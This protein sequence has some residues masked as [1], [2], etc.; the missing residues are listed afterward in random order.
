[1]VA[2]LVACGSSHH[3]PTVG[4]I[5]QP[6][7]SG[8]PDTDAADNDGGS[9]LL[10]G[11][12]GSNMGSG[13]GTVDRPQGKPLALPDTNVSDGTQPTCKVAS[14]CPAM[15]PNCVITADL[16][17]GGP[18]YCSA[19]YVDSLTFVGF[20]AGAKLTDPS[21]LI[22]VC[23]K[24]EHT[25][26]PDLQIELIAPDGKS[27]ILRQFVGRSLGQ[28]YLGHANGCDDDSK[29]VPGVGYEYCW[30]ASAPT[31]MLTADFSTCGAAGGCEQWDGALP[32]ICQTA[33]SKFDVVPAGS[34][35]PDVSFGALK[36]AQLNGTWTFRVTDLWEIDNGFL[37]DWSIQFDSSLVA[38]CSTP[39]I[40]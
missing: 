14:D 35:L 33:G 11:N 27:V 12:G 24:L 15:T 34:Y 39:L 7:D 16:D 21:K 40:K 38:D 23:A 3:P 20:N 4:D 22:S 9:G 6:I 30:T 5:G 29:T 19:S 32:N 26:L 1:V 2:L 28:F 18:G 37:F 10:G 31:K 17:D 36:D 13:C 25:F 8:A